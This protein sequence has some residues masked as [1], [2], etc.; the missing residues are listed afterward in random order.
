MALISGWSAAVRAKRR[1]FVVALALVVLGAGVGGC[2]ADPP[3]PGPTR[4]ESASADGTASGSP[5]AAPGPA[6]PVLPEAA[7]EASEAGARAFVEYYWELVNYAQATG[8]VKALRQL[9]AS[10]CDVCLAFV[11]EIRSLYS[12][13]GRI[14]GGINTSRITE[15]VDLD[16]KS[17]DYGLRIEQDVSYNAQTIIDS[18]GKRDVRG[19]GTDRFTAYLLWTE[20]RWRLDVMEL[21]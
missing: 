9:S 12:Q 10:T 13:G 21:R 8:D 7:R 4:S 1:R 18:T 6:V 15:V 20:Q 2:N 3:D 19:E 16:L 11:K 17:G 14:L 5:T